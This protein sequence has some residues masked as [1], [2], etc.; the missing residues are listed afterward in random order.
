MPDSK[1]EQLLAEIQRVFK[2]TT[3]SG[4]TAFK[5]VFAS[6]YQGREKA[7]QNVLSVLEGTETYLEV[8]SPDKRD[9][10]LDVELDC[11]A[12]VPMGTTL[13]AGGNNVLADLEEIV[14]ANSLWS[15]LAYSTIFQSNLV[16]REDTGDRNVQVTLFIAVQYRTKRSDPRT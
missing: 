14:E 7:G 12:Y 13:R 11:K 10:R 2:T 6:P 5:E 4:G 15:G 8:V 16:E 1:R 3:G 9:R